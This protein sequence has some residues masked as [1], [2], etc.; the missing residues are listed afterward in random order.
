MLKVNWG[1]KAK[2]IIQ[3]IDILVCARYPLVYIISYEEERVKMALE[4][5]CKNRQRSLYVWTIADGIFDASG[6]QLHRA[7]QPYEALTQIR[8][9]KEASVWILKD[10]HSYLNDPLIVRF[11]RN[12]TD[13]SRT[14]GRTLVILSPSLSLPPELEKEITVIEFPLPTYEEVESL[15]DAMIER[16][17]KMV[18]V[19][20]SDEVKERII[21]SSLGLTL[22]E[23]EGLFYQALV[24][25]R[26]L[27]NTDVELILNAKKELVRRSGILEYIEPTQTMEDAGGLYELKRWLQKRKDAFSEEARKFGLPYPK[28]IL[29]VGVQGCGKSLCAKATAALWRLPLL[30]LDMSKIF[31]KYIGSS[32][33]NTAYALKVAEALAPCVLWIDEVEKAFSGA[34]SSGLSDAG[35]TARVFGYFLTWLQEKENAVFV[36]AT[37]NDVSQLPPEFLRRGRFDELF[38]VDLPIPSERSEI[39]KIHLRKRN[40]S[41]N[42]FNINQLLAASEGYTGAEIEQAIISALYDAFDD[43]KRPLTTEDII[44]SLKETVPLSVTMAESVN[45]LRRWAKGRCRPAT[46]TI[47]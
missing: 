25:G 16:Y 30:R 40:R 10:F 15:L 28:G 46:G 37:A 6:T 5:I 13:E 9:N 38:F 23:I 47:D 1:K 14:I 4:D 45:N 2:E 7:S 33:Q 11:L 44:R 29:L 21:H 26:S 8:K 42:N 18:K 34:Q 36:A 43:G 41:P 12:L 22:G 39:F 32:E 31:S 17:S 3:N 20:L 35:T 27:D 24:T 19:H